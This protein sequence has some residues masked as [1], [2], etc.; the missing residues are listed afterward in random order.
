MITVVLVFASQSSAFSQRT[1]KNY[2]EAV[3]ANPLALA[4]GILNVNYEMQVSKD[5]SLVLGATYLGYQGWSG[6]GVS[7]IYKWYMFQDQDKAIK[8]FGFGP[9]A[10]VSFLNY[11]NSSY[12]SRMALSIG[13]EASYKWIID[14]F[15]LEP[16]FGLNYNVLSEAGLDWRPF[17]LGVNLGYAW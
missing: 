12:S 13:G 10:S 1:V 4:F 14:D 9:S 8:G 7:G 11:E 17:Y 2:N 15:V 16:V 3:T 5:N 6:F